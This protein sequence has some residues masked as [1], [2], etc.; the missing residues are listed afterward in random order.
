MSFNVVVKICF[1]L[2]PIVSGIRINSSFHLY[3][4]TKTLNIRPRQGRS[5][6]FIDD[7]IAL[8]FN[9]CVMPLKTTLIRRLIGRWSLK[10]VQE[11]NQSNDFTRRGFGFFNT[12]YI[13]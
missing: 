12:M 10:S 13:V 5:K 11:E 7:M 3:N 8:H 6:Y 4:W 1:E 9:H 2:R